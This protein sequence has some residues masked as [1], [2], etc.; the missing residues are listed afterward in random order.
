MTANSLGWP[1]MTSDDLNWPKMTLSNNENRTFQLYKRCRR[2]KFQ[3][4]WLW[5]RNSSWVKVFQ[6]FSKINFFIVWALILGTVIFLPNFYINISSY[7]LNISS[8]SI[9]LMEFILQ[10]DPCQMR[11]VSILCLPGRVFFRWRFCQSLIDRVCWRER[12]SSKTENPN[13]SHILCTRLYSFFTF[14]ICLIFKNFLSIWKISMIFQIK[15]F[16]RWSR[17][18]RRSFT[19]RRFWWRWR[20]WYGFPPIILKLIL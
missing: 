4:Q 11:P 20:R 14:F 5:I 12:K 8:F 6:K 2:R 3:Y 19:W 9:Y 15:L 10:F 1:W 18:R 13:R 7:F 16:F 17:W